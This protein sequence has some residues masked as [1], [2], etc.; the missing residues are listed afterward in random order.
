MSL[1]NKI[2]FFVAVIFVVSCKEN[3]DEPRARS[4]QVND[5]IHEDGT[6]TDTMTEILGQAGVRIKGKTAKSDWP[7]M[8][9]ELDSPNC[10][11]VKNL[12]QGKDPR[13]P[14]YSWFA[15][16]GVERW[17]M[18]YDGKTKDIKKLLNI[19]LLEKVGNIKGLNMGAPT[20]PT[21]SSFSSI[22][23]LGSTLGDFQSRVN[24][25]N[26]LV[27]EHKLKLDSSTVYI[28]TGKRSFNDVEKAMLT[29]NGS[30]EALN[31]LK[32][33]SE[34][35]GLEW[36]YGQSQKD[37]A[38]NVLPVKV[39]NDACPKGI[40][41]TTESAATLLFSQTAIPNDKKILGVSTHI[42]ALYQYLILKRVAFQNGFTGELEM[43]APALHG[44]ER[45]AY[46]DAKKLAMLLDNIARIFYEICLYKSITG[47][48]PS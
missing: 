25:L 6:I 11:N 27:Q 41:A 1:L 31:V 37:A 34:K 32:A 20:H 30:V 28:L 8:I 48:Y 26:K 18:T 15:K 14:S 2:I 35:V 46:P 3:K 33:D 12:I 21:S 13:Y 42:F 16:P 19:I 10:E 4:T 47:K 39:I 38:L 17:D 22:F 44:S 24:F 45:N 5:L 29:K 43:C 7:E 9:A 23:L 40:R 36:V